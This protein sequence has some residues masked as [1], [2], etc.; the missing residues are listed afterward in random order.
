VS[1]PIPISAF[2]IAPAF[3]LTPSEARATTPDQADRVNVAYRDWVARLRRTYRHRTG[4]SMVRAE[5]VGN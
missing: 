5:I 2:E 3:D 4:A 1:R